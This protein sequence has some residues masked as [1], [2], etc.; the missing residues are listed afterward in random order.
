M[1]EIKS[2]EEILQDCGVDDEDFSWKYVDAM[3]EYA[4]QY[5]K[6]AAERAKVAYECGTWQEYVDDDS[7]LDIIKELK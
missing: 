1:I 2:A 6:L 3:Q 4:K 5:L 7:I